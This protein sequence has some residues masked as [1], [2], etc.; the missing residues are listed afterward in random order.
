MGSCFE[1]RC[2][3]ENPVN[4]LHVESRFGAELRQIRNYCAN[5]DPTNDLGLSYTKNAL[6]EEEDNSEEM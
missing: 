1:C 3:I 5:C 6:P 4:V 2:F